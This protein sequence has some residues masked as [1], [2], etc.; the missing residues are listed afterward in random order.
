MSEGRQRG[1]KNRGRGRGRSKDGKSSVTK[2][3]SIQNSRSSLGPRSIQRADA[4]LIGLNGMLCGNDLHMSLPLPL[5]CMSAIARQ[6]CSGCV[7]PLRDKNASLN[8]MLSE[9]LHLTC[10]HIQL[11]EMQVP[12]M[13]G[14]LSTTASATEWREL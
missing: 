4:G 10:E 12:Q 5:V 1:R 13:H 7:W 11:S 2:T 14:S 3:M 6:C 8:N 9:I